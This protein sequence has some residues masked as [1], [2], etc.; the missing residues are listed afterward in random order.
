[1]NVAD[2]F[3][4]V[5]IHQEFDSF[6]RLENGIFHPVR[7]HVHPVRMHVD[8]CL[9]NIHNLIDESIAALLGER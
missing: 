1:M 7:M 5:S 6:I 4:N 8:G 2:E 9:G 3:W